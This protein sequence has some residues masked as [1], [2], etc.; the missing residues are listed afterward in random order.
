[1]DRLNTD[2]KNAVPETQNQAPEQTPDQMKAANSQKMTGKRAE[3]EKKDKKQEDLLLAIDGAKIKFNA[4]LGTFK[5]LNDVPTTQ[6]KLTGTIVDKQ[7]PNFIFDDGFILTKS[8]EW[9]NF[10]NA[11]VQDN[12]VLLKKSF[13]P[14]VGAVPGTP[15][16]TGKVEFV[17][18][19]QVNIPESIDPK[20]APVLRNTIVEQTFVACIDFYR[21]QL[22]ADGKFGREDTQYN[23]EFGFD[24]F[25]KKVCAEGLASK[26]EKLSNIITKEKTYAGK[27]EYLCPYLSVWGP[28][29]ENNTDNKKSKI[30][31][32]VRANEAFVKSEINEA[33]IELISSDDKIKISPNIVRLSIKGAAQ[34]ISI[35]CTGAF[36]KDV[37]IIAKAK[38]QPQEL[39]K[40]IVKANT[41]Y[42]TIIQ[43]VK[44]TFGTTASTESKDIPHVNLMKDIVKLFNENS[45]NQ[46]YIFGELAATTKH[47]TFLESEFKSFFNDIDGKR[48]LEYS[49]SNKQKAFKY[50]ELM[51]RRFEANN[52]GK[53]DQQRREE[54]L[55]K[56]IENLLKEIDKMYGYKSD[57][58]KKAKKMHEEH[59]VTNIWN[60]QKIK[61]LYDDFVKEK[62]E[63][64]QLYTNSF[65][66]DQN[67]KIY[68]FYTEDIHGAGSPEKEIQAFSLINSGTAQIFNSAL[69]DK[70]AAS[71]II[72]E[73]GHAFGLRHPFEA[74]VMG[75]YQIKE[76][77][78][79]YKQDYEDEIKNLTVEID[80]VIN[81]NI[82]N[83]E[84]LE[85]ISKRD[86]IP[87][88]DLQGLALLNERYKSL[89]GLVADKYS[90]TNFEANFVDFVKNDVIGLE[91][92][93]LSQ[94]SS[95]A[96]NLLQEKENL[97]MKKEELERLKKERKKA[98][99]Y[100]EFPNSKANS[101][102]LENYLDYRQ[103]TDGTFN[104]NFQYKSFY[105]WQWKN[106]I[107]LGKTR[108]YLI[109]IK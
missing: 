73:L 22:N 14:G 21:S 23:G 49:A 47:V 68:F 17:D 59:K 6:D 24:R 98:K 96:V 60:D 30:F 38:E 86:N 48:Y 92:K 2:G 56:K 45:F 15:P 29:T 101:E 9:Q 33:D 5:V 104:S 50:D 36:R 69:T 58:L 95:N 109:E 89:E 57:D 43:P 40:L 51:G 80:S 83:L 108:K 106:M 1:M 42:K 74:E 66:L 3:N 84:K 7:T 31:I 78:Q 27:K 75:R 79:K 55:N 52:S 32:Y 13:L 103:K 20:G 18:S 81:S 10:G 41:I 39:G 93:A 62:A 94:I 71:L 85:G 16:E 4:H 64:N 44:V 35:E 53:A 77:G 100:E 65:K 102:T 54:L 11:K 61:A 37:T 87:I 105:Q 34:K 26:Y 46:A 28:N 19:G 63:Y 97:K 12:E 107:N 90:F 76:N 67:G 72:H 91:G 88:S 25:D 99:S 70:D 82:D 8:I